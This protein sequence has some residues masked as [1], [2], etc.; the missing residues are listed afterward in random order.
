MAKAM[1]KVR[2]V[3]LSEDFQPYWRFHVAREHGRLQAPGDRCIASRKS[4]HT[5]I[6]SQGKPGNV[7]EYGDEP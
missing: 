4:S 7:G 1:L 5:L 2:A 3:Y 6:N